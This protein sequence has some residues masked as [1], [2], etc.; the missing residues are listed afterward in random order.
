MIKYTITV[1][2]NDKDTKK[3]KHFTRY[4]YKEIYKMFDF[5]KIEGATLTEAKGFYRHDNGEAVKEKAIN[6]DLL[7]IEETTVKMMCKYLLKKFNQESV[8]LAINNDYNSDLI[9]YEN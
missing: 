3:Q 8:V 1:G 4:Y 7:F 9:Y 2:L 5:F 6:I